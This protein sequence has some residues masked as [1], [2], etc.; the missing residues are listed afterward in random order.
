MA[1]DLDNVS[2]GRL[3]VEELLRAGHHDIAFVGVHVQGH[4]NRP[5]SRKRAEGWRQ[6]IHRRQ[7]HATLSCVLPGEE[8]AA[9]YD[10]AVAD[11]ARRA[12]D[13]VPGMPA[14]I[15]A[16]D[17]VLITLIDEL[18][19]RGVPQ[20]QWP[21]MVG[22]EGLSDSTGHLVSSVRPRWGDLGSLAADRLIHGARTRAP[23]DQVPMS[24]IARPLMVHLAPRIE[25]V[26]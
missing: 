23:V 17:Y 1:V 5:W 16:D 12:A 14:C 2:G 3:A 9:D 6:A 21:T 8:Y 4:T 24:V 15:G 13:L 7:P 26:R 22:F 10:G 19:R 11:V 25:S 20:E 18:R